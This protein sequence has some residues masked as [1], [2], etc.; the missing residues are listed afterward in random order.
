M[1]PCRNSERPGAQKACLY[2]RATLPH[3]ICT[4]AKGYPNQSIDGQLYRVVQ[5]RASHRKNITIELRP[6]KYNN[7]HKRDGSKGAKCLLF[8][9]WYSFHDHDDPLG[10]NVQPKRAKTQP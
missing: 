10:I 7:N 9:M 1:R 6:D 5:S 8:L 4:I 3:A 2:V